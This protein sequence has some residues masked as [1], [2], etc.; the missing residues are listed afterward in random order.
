MGTVSIVCPV[1]HK[2]VSF[3]AEKKQLSNGHIW[4]VNQDCPH[5]CGAHFNQISACY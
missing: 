1:C 5:G 3:E 4:E 2:A